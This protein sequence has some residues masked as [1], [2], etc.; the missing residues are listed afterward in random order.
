MMKTQ[1]SFKQEEYS[2]PVAKVY[3]ISMEQTVM[4]NEPINPPGPDIPIPDE[5]N[6]SLTGIW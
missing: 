4:S 5:G 3:Y 2:S 1:Y 6:N